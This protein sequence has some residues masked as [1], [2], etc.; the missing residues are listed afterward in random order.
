MLIVHTTY[1]IS[2]VARATKKRS[3]CLYRVR[4]CPFTLCQSEMIG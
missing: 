3:D 4:F 1:N 2:R